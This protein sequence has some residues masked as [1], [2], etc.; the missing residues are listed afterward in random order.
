MDIPEDQWPNVAQLNFGGLSQQ[1]HVI[2]EVCRDAIR[3]VEVTL[4]T[5]HA[6]PEIYGGTI[7]KRRVLLEAIKTL[8]ANNE[9]KRRDVDYKTLHK[10]IS[11]DEKFSRTIGKWVRIFIS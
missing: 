4:V 11:E 10:R 5:Q 2:R 3:I 7:Y 1:G 9:D 6:W 8:R